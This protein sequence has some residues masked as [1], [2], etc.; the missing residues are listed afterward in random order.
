MA[1]TVTTKDGK[2]HPYPTAT[3]CVPSVDLGVTCVHRIDGT[4]SGELISWFPTADVAKVEFFLRT[5]VAEATP[6]VDG[7]PVN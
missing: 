5:E 4:G 6:V 1:I 2:L 3:T 7:M